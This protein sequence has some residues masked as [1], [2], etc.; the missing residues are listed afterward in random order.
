MSCI[1]HDKANVV[2]FRKPQASLDVA[3]NVSIRRDIDGIVGSLAEQTLLVW[4]CPR[5]TCVALPVRIY[6]L[7]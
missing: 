3:N 1:F 5:A 6:N 4:G 2:R 7:A